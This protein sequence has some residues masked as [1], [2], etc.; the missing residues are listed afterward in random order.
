MAE[1]AHIV[2]C[3]QRTLVRHIATGRLN[4]GEPHARR[5]VSRAD[6]EALALQLPSSRVSFNADTSYWI[7]ATGAAAILGPPR[8]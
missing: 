5:R 7:G 2:G 1:A 6:A 8:R 4:A 3:S